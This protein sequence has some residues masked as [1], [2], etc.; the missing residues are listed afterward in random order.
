MKLSLVRDTDGKTCTLGKMFI[1]DDF[2]CHSLEDVDRRLELGG[3]KI[4]GQTAIP[5]GTYRVIID[6]SQRF[7]RDLPRLLSVPQFEGIRIHPGNTA[8]DT[9]GCILVGRYRVGDGSVSQSVLAFKTL[10]NKIQAAIARGEEVT[11]EVR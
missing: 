8:A 7:K 6:R 2:E 4:Y 5:R 10:F 11:I 9:H 3:E 1:D